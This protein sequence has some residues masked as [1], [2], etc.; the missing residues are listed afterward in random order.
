MEVQQEISR[1]IE[2]A[3]ERYEKNPTSEGQEKSVMEKMIA[4]D[5]NIAKTMAE[6]MLTAGVDT[7]SMGNALK[8]FVLFILYLH[9]FSM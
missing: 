6:D 4:I 7:T 1:Y 5:K 2:D 9:T 8:L 3:V